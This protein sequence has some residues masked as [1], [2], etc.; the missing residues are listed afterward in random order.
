MNTKFVLICVL[1]ASLQT[2]CNLASPTM[3]PTTLLPEAPTLEFVEPA[4]IQTV[5]PTHLPTTISIQPSATPLSTNQEVLD[6]AAEV[7]AALK[8]EDM[9]ILSG[10]VHPR[11]GLR[12][13]PYAFVRDTDQVFLADEVASLLIDSKVYTWGHYSGS[14]APIDLGFPA[15]YSQFVYDV[16]FANAT[17]MALNHRLGVSTS[18]DNSL[19]F[20]PGTMIVEYYFPG[21]DAQFHG[22]DWRSLRLVFMEDNNTWYLVGIIHDQWTT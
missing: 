20:Y 4:A 8:N 17:Q 1:M 3:V 5:L 10:Y 16:D 14:G 12:S 9:T 15:Y 18:M 21:F 22:M 6:E 13:S 7:I 2:G 19:E 11:L